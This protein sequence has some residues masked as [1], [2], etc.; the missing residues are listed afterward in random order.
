MSFSFLRAPIRKAAFSV[1][2]PKAQLRTTFRTFSTPPTPPPPKTKNTAFFTGLGAAAAVGIAFY[3]YTSTDA[4]KEAGSAVK[5][6]IQAAKVKA[7]FT[8]TKDDYQKVL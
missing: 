8:P 2:I 5:S 6:G 3:F 1:S 7:K 4:G